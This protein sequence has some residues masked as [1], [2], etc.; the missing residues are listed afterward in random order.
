MIG[1]DGLNGEEGSI[2]KG[3]GIY[4]YGKTR[5][6]E[7]RE[8][9]CLLG[10]GPPEWTKLLLPFA[11]AVC[12]LHIRLDAR[13]QLP[14]MM[15][16]LATVVPVVLLS[17]ERELHAAHQCHGRSCGSEC[18]ACCATVLDFSRGISS[19]N[20]VDRVQPRDLFARTAHAGAALRSAQA[21]SCRRWSC[22]RD[23]ATAESIGDRSMGGGPCPD[24]GA[25]ARGHGLPWMP[26]RQADDM[27]TVFGV[28]SRALRGL[29]RQRPSVR[30]AWDE[31]L[32]RLP[33]E[34]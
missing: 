31:E 12:L 1:D 8:A 32:S 10:F 19:L 13:P 14:R 26:W 21:R 3:V 16:L 5:E 22:S 30:A 2:A 11:D 4:Q 27:S 6:A 20:R 7:R 29:R 18:C 23:W 34:G 15:R 24:R 17:S 9:A 33:R 28:H 25:L